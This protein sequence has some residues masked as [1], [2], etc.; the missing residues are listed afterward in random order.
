MPT[1][2]K[3]GRCPFHLGQQESSGFVLQIH[4]Q[5]FIYTTVKKP[6]TV[7]QGATVANDRE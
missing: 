1:S 3:E 4:H 7:G 6:G 2:P 5:S